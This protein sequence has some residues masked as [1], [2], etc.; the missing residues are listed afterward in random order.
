MLS[1]PLRCSL[2]VSFFAPGHPLSDALDAAVR[3]GFRTV[4]LLDPYAHDLDELETALAARGLRVDLINLPMGDFAAGERGYAGD[5]GRRQLFRTDVEQAAGVIE[6][7]RPAKVNALA[8]S[9]VEGVSEA[10]QRR[11]LVDQLGWAA[12]RL[13]GSDVVVTTELLNP[14][15]TPGFLLDSI[16]GVLA[17]LD[18]L[19]GHVRF[20]LDVYHLSRSGHDVVSVIDALASRTGHIQIADAPGRTEPGSGDIDFEAVF[21]AIT[22]SRYSGYIGCEFSPSSAGADVFGWMDAA[23]VLRG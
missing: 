7:L 18:Q 17:A 9:R 5:P 12:A 13:A 1:D 3:N 11:C 16:E 6:R 14:V 2:N 22:R 8:G 20:Q 10:V 21:S 4:E 19:D 15:E 23:G